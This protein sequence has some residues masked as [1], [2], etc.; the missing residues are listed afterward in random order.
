MSDPILN[1]I[2]CPQCSGN[3]AECGHTFLEISTDG[4]SDLFRK[5]ASIRPSWEEY[6]LHIAEAVATRADCSRRQVGAV[7]VRDHRIV[8]TGYNGGR[9]NGPSCLAGECPRGRQTHAERP[10]YAEGNNDYSDCIAIHAELN[11]LLFSSRA[12]ILGGT[13][14]CTVKPCKECWKVIGNSGLTGVVYREESAV[15]RYSFHHNEW[16]KKDG[17]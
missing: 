8:S 5:L 6:F 16:I 10:G 1:F 9:A 14:Y 3:L 7:I 13:L 2:L 11:C 15:V 4:P 12:E 17:S